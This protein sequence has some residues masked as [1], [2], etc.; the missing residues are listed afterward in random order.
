MERE[1]VCCHQRLSFV[2]G[3]VWVYLFI[4]FTRQSSAAK[5]LTSELCRSARTTELLQG[6][7]TSLRSA[8]IY[9]FALCHGCSCTGRWRE[10]P[11]LPR[12]VRWAARLS[13]SGCSGTCTPG[14]CQ[15]RGGPLPWDVPQGLHRTAIGADL[16]LCLRKGSGVLSPSLR[17]TGASAG[18]GY[19]LPPWQGVSK[20][21]AAEVVALPLPSQG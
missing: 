14:W 15:P 20:T 9:C 18:S 12:R 13:G 7:C 5:L 6:A 11:G 17:R 21:R 4:C 19:S 16:G 1:A 8:R 2:F 3:R 10:L